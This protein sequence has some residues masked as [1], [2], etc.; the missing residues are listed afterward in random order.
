MDNNLNNPQKPSQP[1]S[2]MDAFRKALSGQNN[3]SITPSNKIIASPNLSSNSNKLSTPNLAT[4]LKTINP[5]SQQNNSSQPQDAETSNVISFVNNVIE[6][7]V[8]LKVSDI[9]IE[10][11]KESARIR[12]R[13]D[14]G[15]KEIEEYKNF[16]YQ[17]YSAITT[18]VKILASLDISERR[19]PQD[20]AIS[21]PYQGSTVDIRV[22]VLPTGSGERVVM[23]LM[24]KSSLTLPLDKLGF[25]EYSLPKIRKAINSPQ[26]MILVTG[27]TGS[28][29]STTLY[30]ILNELNKQDV[31]ILTAE[32]PVEFE[33][34]GIGQ[35]HVKESIGLS[36]SS[37][38][39]SFLR[40]DPEVIMVG[41]IRDKE[42]GDIAVKAALTG[43]LVLSTLHTNSAPSTI[44]RLINMGIPGY[45]IAPSLNLV[46]AQRLARVNCQN[47]LV[48]DKIDIDLLR[49]LGFA[50]EELNNIKIYK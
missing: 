47:C 13:R 32:D 42:T 24:D 39:R 20:G 28:G 1:L 26:G 50:E 18:R 30:A 22:S 9:H 40:Q 41:E 15:L 2:A 45:L 16:L 8:T 35:V 37:A 48:E 19:L 6:N 7:A 33:V 29:K 31:N 4:N 3:I 12:Y 21:F 34:H 23:R 10:P 44:T 14:G 38:L 5:I 27:P 36:F 11:Y 46:I 49:S 25:P 43:H 17:N